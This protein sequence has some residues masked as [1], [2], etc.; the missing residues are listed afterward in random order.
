MAKDK[1]DGAYVVIEIKRNQTSDDTVGQVTRYMEWLEEE[2][3]AS[4]VI[5]DGK[6]DSELY[7]S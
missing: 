1:A 3:R 5:A 2:L 4:N 7:Y 6:H